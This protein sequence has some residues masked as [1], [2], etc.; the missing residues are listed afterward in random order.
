MFYSVFLSPSFG[1]QLMSF[2][3]YS[4]SYFHSI[5]ISVALSVSLLF[6]HRSF[7]FPRAFSFSLFY[8]F[9]PSFAV[10]MRRDYTGEENTGDFRPKWLKERNAKGKTRKRRIAA[11][12]HGSKNQFVLCL[13]LL[14]LSLSKSTLFVSS[15]SARII[16]TEIFVSRVPSTV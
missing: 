9:F 7:T 10:C 6:P 1:L 15:A 4:Y 8:S 11:A 3:S 16:E 5:S 14:C 13:L 2:S 12:M